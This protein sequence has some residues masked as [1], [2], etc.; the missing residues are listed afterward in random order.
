L[1]GALRELEAFSQRLRVTELRQ[2]RGAGVREEDLLIIVVEA[3][4]A[5]DVLDVL[6]LRVGEKVLKLR[7]VDR[8]EDSVVVGL[9]E[10]L[11]L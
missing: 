4:K 9:V 1:K 11:D 10:A 5:A 6:T 7:C 8:V 2:L 3:L